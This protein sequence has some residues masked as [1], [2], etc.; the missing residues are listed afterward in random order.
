MEKTCNKCGLSKNLD[1]FTKSKSSKDGFR[2]TCKKCT[3]TIKD[4]SK[5]KLKQKEYRLKNRD[6]KI[7]YM[8]LYN[9]KPENKKRVKQWFEKNKNRINEVKRYNRKYK[10]PHVEA[11]RRLLYRLLYQFDKPK[12]FSTH[13]LLGYSALELK[14]HISN[15]F[16]EGMSWN[17]HGEW[18]IDHIKPVSDF[19]ENTHPSVVNALSNLRPIW[20]TT[21]EING[22]IYEGNLNRYKITNIKNKINAEK[23]K[24]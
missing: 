5:Y 2:N 19:N 7:K 6:T 9:S 3:N 22:V 18:H 21:R 17:N 23:D 15:L 8:V 13:Q 11:W 16:T 1:D 4:N 20:A 24:N 14:N 12:E 10:T